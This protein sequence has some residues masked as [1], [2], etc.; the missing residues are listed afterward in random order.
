MA[1]IAFKSFCRRWNDLEEAREGHSRSSEIALSDRP[2][3]ISLQIPPG[4]NSERGERMGRKKFVEGKA[5]MR[6]EK[7]KRKN[8]EVQ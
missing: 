7:S 5:G 2:R 4:E 3:V 6:V 8:T 1:E